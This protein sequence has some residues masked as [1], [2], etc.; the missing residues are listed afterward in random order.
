[1]ELRN[2]DEIEDEMLVALL[3][4][5]GAQRERFE[6]GQL[7]WDK[8]ND[9]DREFLLYW[10]GAVFVAS[11]QQH[12][13]TRE[14]A[15]DGATTWAIGHSVSVLSQMRRH[16]RRL[17]GGEN[18]A[19]TIFGEERAA[20]F[21]VTEVSQAASTGGEFAKLA[22]GEWSQ[23]DL[24]FTAMDERVCAYCG[25][26]HLQ[27]RSRWLQIYQN[28]ILPAHPEFAVYGEPERTPAH[29]NCR[30]FILYLGESSDDSNR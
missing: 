22:L 12:G 25:P 26:L 21:V 19:D 23:D 20:R 11:A 17:L 16:T 3:L 1:M 24:W 9:E 30:C 7:D 14:Q 6:A 4:L 29:P 8:K 5:W 13:L 2:R 28:S 15:L 10:L 18:A 27:P